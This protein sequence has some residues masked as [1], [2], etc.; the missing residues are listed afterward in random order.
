MHGSVHI[1][2][3]SNLSEIKINEKFQLS[4]FQPDQNM[5]L[6][7]L[8]SSGTMDTLQVWLNKNK[9]DHLLPFALRN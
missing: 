9:T 8:P 6:F 3:Y 7:D 2:W 4:D 1:L 5:I